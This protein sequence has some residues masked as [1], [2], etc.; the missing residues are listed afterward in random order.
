MDENQENVN[1]EENQEIQ[2]SEENIYN[3]Q[4][5]AG[6]KNE[7]EEGKFVILYYKF[8]FKINLKKIFFLFHLKL[9]NIDE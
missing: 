8:F 7:V 4:E 5:D 3:S 9:N 1:Y 6:E 2:I